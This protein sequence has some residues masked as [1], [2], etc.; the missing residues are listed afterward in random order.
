MPQY[1]EPEF[2]LDTQRLRQVAFLDTDRPV[3]IAVY[4]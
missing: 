2:P 4:G 3:G 1:L